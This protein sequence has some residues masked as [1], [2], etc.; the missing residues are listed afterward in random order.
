LV[1]TST[2]GTLL[3]WSL[4]EKNLI[5]TQP[6]THQDEINCLMF[7]EYQN[8]D[9]ILTGSGVENSLKIW[10]KQEASDTNYTCLRQRQ[11]CASGLKSAKFYGEDSRHII[12]YS[13]SPNCEIYDFSVLKEEMTAQLSHVTFTN[14]Y[15]LFQAD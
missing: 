11:G 7:L 13:N 8:G 1:S 2:D 10:Y 15:Y 12:S 9:L 6:L 4:N 14:L 3:F 5:Q